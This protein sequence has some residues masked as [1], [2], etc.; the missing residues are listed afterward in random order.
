MST[1]N[2]ES[3]TTSVLKKKTM[4]PLVNEQHPFQLDVAFAQL[5]RQEVV[6]KKLVLVTGDS[7][8]TT[9]SSTLLLFSPWLRSILSSL[10]CSS[11]H[12]PTTIL[13]PDISTASLSR[14]IELVSLGSSS[15]KCNL[16]EVIKTVGDAR[17]LNIDISDLVE[18]AEPEDELK[19]DKQALRESLRLERVADEEE[20]RLE[21]VEN[22]NEARLS[23]VENLLQRVRTEM[24][25]GDGANDEITDEET[26]DKTVEVGRKKIGPKVTAS[27]TTSSTADPNTHE[28]QKCGQHLPE[29]SIDLWEHYTNHYTAAILRFL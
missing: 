28:C 15:S 1:I 11:N 24:T 21:K 14:I 27:S 29:A 19:E 2:P 8:I 18:V 7:S 23:R 22:E 20:A 10:P 13:I 16:K 3:L 9:S 5:K 4:S 26:I 17:L 6:E 12:S 25:D